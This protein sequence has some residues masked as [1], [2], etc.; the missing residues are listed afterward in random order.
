MKGV[1]ISTREYSVKENLKLLSENLEKTQMKINSDKNGEKIKIRAEKASRLFNN[2]KSK[3]EM[4][5][6]KTDI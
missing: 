4:I 5:N 6:K 3:K 1:K 2:I